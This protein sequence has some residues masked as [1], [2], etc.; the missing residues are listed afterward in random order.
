MLTRSK[1]SGVEEKLTKSSLKYFLFSCL[2][3]LDRR[4]GI[5]AVDD[6][7]DWFGAVVGSEDGARWKSVKSSS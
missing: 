2:G 4:L 3:R 1:G 6:L 7:S 5:T